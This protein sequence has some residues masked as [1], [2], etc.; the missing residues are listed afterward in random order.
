MAKFRILLLLLLVMLLAVPAYAEDPQISVPVEI[1]L[2][3]TQPYPQ[4]VYAVEVKADDPTYPMPAGSQNGTFTLTITGP[5]KVDLPA[6]T[7]TQTG[8]Y[9]YVIRELK[10]GNASCLSYDSR[11]YV[12]TVIVVN[13]EDG[14]ETT[15]TLHLDTSEDKLTQVSFQ[16][17]YKTVTVDPVTPKTGDESNLRLYL[18]LAGVSIAVLTVLILTGRRRNDD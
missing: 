16:N 4:E 8:V 7:Y 11:V 12:L 3:G 17:Q 14:F 2:T 6:I 13:G 9:T 10:G 15:T 18:I 5:R 1:T